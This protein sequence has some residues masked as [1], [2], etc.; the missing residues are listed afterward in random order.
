MIERLMVAAKVL[1]AKVEGG[2]KD[3]KLKAKGFALDKKGDIERINI[4]DFA[5]KSMKEQLSDS[6]TLNEMVHPNQ[7]IKILRY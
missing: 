6:N 2:G 4:F 5:E 3:E 7:A 1:K